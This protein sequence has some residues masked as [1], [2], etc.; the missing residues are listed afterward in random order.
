MAV[1]GGVLRD[2][3]LD[4]AAGNEWCSLET[5]SRQTGPGFTGFGI[6]VLG[7]GIYLFRV[8]VRC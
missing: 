2:L 8:W 4:L 1:S 5:G 3:D 6:R 7:F